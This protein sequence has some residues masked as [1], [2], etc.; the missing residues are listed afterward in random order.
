[1]TFHDRIRRSA[2]LVVAT[3]LAAAVATPVAAAAKPGTQVQIGG[4]LVAPAQLSSWQAQAGQTSPGHLV[5]IGG[6]LVAPEN[7]SSFQ[8]HAGQTSP[9]HLVQVGG[10]LVAPESVSS[11]QAHASQTTSPVVASQEA[12]GS[13]FDWGQAGIGFGA[14]LGAILFVAASSYVRRVRLTQA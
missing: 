6:T 13:G 1:M 9:G 10:T 4:E 14:A 11:F 2:R 5:Q 3:G 12:S 7:V 8:A